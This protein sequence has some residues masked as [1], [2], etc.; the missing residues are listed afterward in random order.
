VPERSLPRLPS[1]AILSACALSLALGCSPEP[2][3]QPIRDEPPYICMVIPKKAPNLVFD[4][5]IVYGEFQFNDPEAR[6]LDV[7]EFR[8][9]THADSNPSGEAPNDDI[10]YTQLRGLRAEEL[11]KEWQEKSADFVPT[12]AVVGEARVEREFINGVAL[13]Y[14][15]CGRHHILS[16]IQYEG[17][18]NPE[19]DYQKD[20][21]TLLKI[22]QRRYA[23]LNKCTPEPPASSK[24]G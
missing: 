2:K 6:S 3:A 8:C 1:V 18:P 12:S 24:A 5:D 9:A 15:K 4:T 11:N 14:W 17:E 23:E 16:E 21:T 7:D 13:T 19:R 22:A 10:V 20:L